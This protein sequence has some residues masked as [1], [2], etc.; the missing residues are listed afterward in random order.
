[1]LCC[2]LCDSKFLH[3]L[4]NEEFLVITGG[5]YWDYQFK[6]LEGSKKDK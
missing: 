1:M 3:G 4:H 2:A 5:A 6:F